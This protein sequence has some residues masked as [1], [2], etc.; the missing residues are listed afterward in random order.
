MLLHVNTEV[1]DLSS[2]FLTILIPQVVAIEIALIHGWQTNV[3][4]LVPQDLSYVRFL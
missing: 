2:Y 1:I 3:I 4:L